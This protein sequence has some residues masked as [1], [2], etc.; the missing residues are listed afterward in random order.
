MHEFICVRAFHG[1]AHTVPNERV[2]EG[3]CGA[4]NHGV[5]GVHT[6]DK[7]TVEGLQADGVGG[8]FGGFAGAGHAGFAGFA[9]DG[10]FG[11]LGC[12]F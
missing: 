9:G 5:G 4:G 7:G 1:D 8:V 11:C 3:F 12:G 6:N 10:W 2:H